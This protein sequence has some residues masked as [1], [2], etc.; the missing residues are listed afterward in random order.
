MHKLIN[1]QFCQNF[2]SEFIF[3]VKERKCLNLLELIFR[4]FHVSNGH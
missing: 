3:R 2:E 4:Q 1:I